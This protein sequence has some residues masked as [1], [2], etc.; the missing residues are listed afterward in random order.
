MKHKEVY[1]LIHNT[2][3]KVELL[4]QIKDGIIYPKSRAN[5]PFVTHSK[6]S[7]QKVNISRCKFNRAGRRIPDGS[8]YF[9][10]QNFMYFALKQDGGDPLKT[11]FKIFNQEYIFTLT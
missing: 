7:Y 11:D 4:Q 1:L 9:P 5:V 8:S 10:V 2:G 6:S 3:T